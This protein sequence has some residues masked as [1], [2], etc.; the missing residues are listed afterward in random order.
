M[1]S[2]SLI[3]GSFA[4]WELI[5][6]VIITVDP[7]AALSPIKVALMKQTMI[8][9]PNLLAR[10]NDVMIEY[11]AMKAN[12]NVEEYRLDAGKRA[13]AYTVT[14]LLIGIMLN[15]VCTSHILIYN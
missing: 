1:L 2:I 7:T 15:T 10:T 3:L 4:F 12:M 14:S 6:Q 11:Q 9:N 13:L 5:P 8:E